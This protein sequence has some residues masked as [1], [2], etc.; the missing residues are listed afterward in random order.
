MPPHVI[1][2]KFGW[3]VTDTAKAREFDAW[4]REQKDVQIYDDFGEYL[5]DLD[6]KTNPN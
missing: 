5:R 4:Y 3:D 2:P 6:E 1:G